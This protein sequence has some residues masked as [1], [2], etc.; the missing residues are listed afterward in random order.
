MDSYFSS[1]SSFVL[2]DDDG[3]EDNAVYFVSSPSGNCHSY[4]HGTATTDPLVISSSSQS[5]HGHGHGHGV[6]HAGSDDN[7]DQAHTHHLELDHAHALASKEDENLNH[8]SVNHDNAHQGGDHA[9]INNKCTDST[10]EKE[11]TSTDSIRSETKTT[12]INDN[13][14]ITNT[15][16]AVVDTYN[17]CPSINTEMVVQ[18]QVHNTESKEASRTKEDEPTTKK[19]KK[20]HARTKESRKAK[21]ERRKRTR[22]EQEE[23]AATLDKN[24][25]NSNKHTSLNGEAHQDDGE[26]KLQSQ[27][28]TERDKRLLNSNETSTSSSRKKAKRRHGADRTLL[29]ADVVQTQGRE[30]EEGVGPSCPSS[31]AGPAGANTNDEK[32]EDEDEDED[33]HTLNNV[34]ADPDTNADEILILGEQQVQ[35]KSEKRSLKRI[36]RKKKRQRLEENRMQ[37]QQ[38][39]SR[40]ECKRIRRRNR[41][42]KKRQLRASTRE[43]DDGVG[44]GVDSEDHTKR[45][46]T[47]ATATASA[48]NYNSTTVEQATDSCNQLLTTVTGTIRPRGDNDADA[49]IVTHS[50]RPIDTN[51]ETAL[52]A[53]SAEEIVLVCDSTCNDPEEE[54]AGPVLDECEEQEVNNDSRTS[55]S[56]GKSEF[57][58]SQKPDPEELQSVGGEEELRPLSISRTSMPTSIPTPTPIVQTP[59]PMRYSARLRNRRC[60]SVDNNRDDDTDYSVEK[61]EGDSSSSSHEVSEEEYEEESDGHDDDDG[62][63]CAESSCEEKRQTKTRCRNSNNNE[64]EKNKKIDNETHTAPLPPKTDDKKAKLTGGNKNK[65][66]RINKSRARLDESGL[67]YR[68]RLWQT[69]YQQLM[70]FQNEFGHAS[71]PSSYRPNKPLANW[72]V[73]QRQEYRKWKMGLSQI[74]T[75]ERVKALSDMGF[76]WCMSKEPKY[77]PAWDAQFEALKRYKERFG[78]TLVPQRWRESPQLGRWVETQRRQYKLRQEGNKRHSLTPERVAKFDALGFRWTMRDRYEEAFDKHISLLKAFVTNHDKLP[79][80]KDGPFLASWIGTCKVQHTNWL[81]GELSSMTPQRRDALI[82]VGVKFRLLKRGEDGDDASSSISSNGDRSISGEVFVDSLP[83]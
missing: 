13:N 59:S 54:E 20:K 68:Q 82:E 44:V 41:K 62:G 63:E 8:S 28:T 17:K 11:P 30:Q 60:V 52:L 25:T 9:V 23:T 2:E 32:E 79:Q 55:N 39:P 29:A 22:Q 50:C 31:T 77:L 5:Q 69:R 81:K 43:A 75:P 1:L 67:N 12:I 27:A 3:D 71:V 21:K 73:C 74:M 70:E 48:N 80:E 35:A 33:E 7:D 83:S 72:V 57:A 78:D 66:H 34:D 76:E 15:L 47:I 37:T 53:L 19:K 45:E 18:T 61:E 42:E 26:S 56:S 16:V 6:L 14:E 24:N 64:C 4:F 58:R 38:E 10:E 49:T 65:R 46:C 40:R 36:K 51:T